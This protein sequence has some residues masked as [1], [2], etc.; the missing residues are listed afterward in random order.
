M[1]GS[2]FSLHRTSRDPVADGVV[3]YFE[4]DDLDATVNRL[5]SAG[6]RFETEPQDQP[7]LWREAYLRDPAGNLVCLF[8]AGV[9]RRNPPWRMGDR[10]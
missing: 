9:N 7:W 2:T 3:V 1:G 5:K 10:I 6:L 4:L 8:H